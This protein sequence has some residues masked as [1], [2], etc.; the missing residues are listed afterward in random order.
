MTASLVMWGFAMITAALV[1][2]EGWKKYL[3]TQV[4]IARE[5]SLGTEA[6][7]KLQ[8]ELERLKDAHD[9][10][11]SDLKRRLSEKDADVEELERTVRRVD[12]DYR[13]LIQK[14]LEYYQQKGR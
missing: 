4:E 2:L 5:K 1:A 12:D 9:K 11:I 7:K 3:N 14:T 6:L 10:E 13:M 8:I